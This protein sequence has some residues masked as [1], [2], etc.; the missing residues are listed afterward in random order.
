[1]ALDPGIILPLMP[2]SPSDV[3]ILDDDGDWSPS[4]LGGR[5]GEGGPDLR[6][7]GRLTV[8]GRAARGPVAGVQ[9]LGSTRGY[10]P[11]VSPRHAGGP[12]PVPALRGGRGSAWAAARLLL[13]AG[14]RGRPS[15]A[16][17]GDCPP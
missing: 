14:G 1:M 15:A 8:C 3:A 17:A 7:H 16:R 13:A 4:A 10:A 5:G 11:G 2:P 6:C 9:R 12:D